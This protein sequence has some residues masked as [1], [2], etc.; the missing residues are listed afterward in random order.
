MLT[1]QGFQDAFVQSIS[2]FTGLGLGVALGLSD[3]SETPKKSLISSFFQI[4]MTADEKDKSIHKPS[5]M[6][7]V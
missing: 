4:P 7:Q 3:D 5:T 2:Q 6:I 1:S